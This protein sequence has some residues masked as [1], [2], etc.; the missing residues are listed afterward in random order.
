[1]KVINSVFDILVLSMYK[2]V[3]AILKLIN[4]Q[5]HRKTDVYEN[6]RKVVLVPDRVR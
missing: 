5:P 2:N 4:V 6:I 3:Y 1:M